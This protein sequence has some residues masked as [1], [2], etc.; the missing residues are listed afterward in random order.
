MAKIYL[1]STEENFKEYRRTVYEALHKASHQ[2]I[3]MENYMAA[4][5][6]PFDQC[7]KK[8]GR[9]DNLHGDLRVSLGYIPAGSQQSQWRVNYGAGDSAGPIQQKP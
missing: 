2:V 4:D 5:Q 7:L 6:R 8:V 9:S 3:A 1:F